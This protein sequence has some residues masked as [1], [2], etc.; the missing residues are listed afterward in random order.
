MHFAYRRL[1]PATG[2]A[3]SSAAQTFRALVRRSLPLRAGCEAKVRDLE[4]RYLRTRLPIRFGAAWFVLLVLQLWGTARAAGPEAVQIQIGPV[5]GT[6]PATF[7]VSLNQATRV[8]MRTFDVQDKQDHEVRGV[9]FRSLLALANVPKSADTALIL[10]TDGM[11]IPV[12]L[13][14]KQTIDAIFIALEH[15]DAKEHFTTRYPLFGGAT[16]LSCPKVIY[17]GK[18]GDA[19]TIWRYPMEFGG[20]RF[21]TWTSYEAELAQPTRAMQDRSGWPIYVR[22]C[23][24]CHGIGGQGAKRG[25]DFSS[26]MDAYRR[27][28]PHAYTGWD[29]PPSLHEKIKGFEDGAMHV[30][31]HISNAEISALWR[32]LHAVHRGVSK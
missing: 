28:R 16:E 21:V 17:A 29:E 14:D 18:V 11:Q 5:T 7:T 12:R 24:P 6:A 25:P 2:A 8:R 27:I 31:N 30:L 20:V 3:W 32:W 9:P 4:A 13:A 26:N 19:Y 23:Q 22:H 10:Y 1:Q 15:G